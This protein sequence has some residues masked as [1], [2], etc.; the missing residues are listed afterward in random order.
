M[1][2]RSRMRTRAAPHHSSSSPSNI[3]ALSGSA[4]TGVGS[5]GTAVFTSTSNM[6]DATGVAAGC[7]SGRASIVTA[8]VPASAPGV[9]VPDGSV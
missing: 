5:A 8:A 3:A 7:P 4:G 6:T 9:G 2:V 1:S